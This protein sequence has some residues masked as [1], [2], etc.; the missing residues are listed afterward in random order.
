[1]A[2]QFPYMDPLFQQRIY[3]GPLV[4]GPAVAWNSA[5]NMLVR[6]G[7]QINVLNLTPNAVH[8]GTNINGVISTVAVPGLAGSGY[9]MANCVDG[10][11]YVNT[12]F[13]L[14]RFNPNNLAAPAQNLGGFPGQG[15]SITT[16]PNGKVAYSDTSTTSNV[17]LYDPSANTHSLI[18]TMPAGVNVDD[19]EAG[20]GGQIALAG[21]TGP[22]I[23]IINQTG[24][25][26]N[27]FS[28][29]ATSYPD[30]LAYGA[31]P[32]ANSI[33]ANNNDG[34]IIRYDFPSP[35]Y[36]GS[37]L[38]VYIARGAG[39]NN[40]AGPGS[41]GDLAAVGPDCAFYVFNANNN[42]LNFSVSGAGT[43]WDN[44]VLTNDPSL[45][46][47]NLLGLTGGPDDE[48]GFFSIFDVPEPSSMIA[49][50][51]AGAILTRRVR[52]G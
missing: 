21:Q 33:F 37:P 25:V 39:T 2:V 3:N 50:S 44:G 45:T 29:P 24:G 47:I 41:Y 34:S 42:G 14:Q 36:T 20:P 18:Y 26:I 30:G 5:G 8:Q 46:R 35:G 51:A 23:H 22:A 10:F 1:M 48:C 19:M 7:S 13:G 15:F 12:G 40:V 38:A 52:R 49:L 32:F 11:V 9:G 17:Y 4:G 16:L 6:N 27:S 43:R 28:T 31:G